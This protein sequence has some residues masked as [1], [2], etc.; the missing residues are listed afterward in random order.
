MMLCYKCS[1]SDRH[2]ICKQF[3]LIFISLRPKEFRTEQDSREAE[4]DWT[5]QL[6]SS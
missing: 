6:A 4:E 5:S 1:L 2:P 3:L